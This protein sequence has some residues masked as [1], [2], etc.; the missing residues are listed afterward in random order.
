MSNDTSDSIFHNICISH[1][2]SSQ[3][4]GLRELWKHTFGDS[5]AFLDAFFETA[6]SPKRT[7][8]VT[9]NT[10]VVG[11]LYWFDC[12]FSN[13]KIA[14]IYA[15]ATA[16]NY[17]GQRICHT[18]MT[19]T[20]Q[21]LKASG[22]AGAI[23]SPAEESLFHFYGKMGYKTCAYANELHYTNKQNLVSSIKIQKISKEEFAK[24][25]REFLPPDAV[26]QEHENLD[27]LE[28]EAEFYIGK[29]FLL[30]AQIIEKYE[31]TNTGTRMEKHLLGIE[32]LGDTS[33]FPSILTFFGCTSGEFRTIGNEKAIG[34]Y[35]SFTNTTL[36]PAYLGFIFD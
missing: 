6:F 18:L 10:L 12:E 9:I 33:I 27:F 36:E 34:M 4:T 15:V 11:A 32:L 23:L 5:D 30:T 20:H 25:R 29:D 35:H 8:C 17:R 14:Y 22:Y 31:E 13:Q 1:P 3:I 21:Y 24:L 26:L 28:K 19:H 16:K 7:F 2:D